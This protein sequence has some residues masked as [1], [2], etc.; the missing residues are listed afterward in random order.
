MENDRVLRVAGALTFLAAAQ[1]IILIT[2][3]EAFYPD[4]S[5]LNN[6]LSD[7]G[8]TCRDTCTIVYP[9]SVIFNSALIVSGLLSLTSAYLILRATGGKRFTFFLG[10]FGLGTLVAGVFPETVIGAHELGS[11]V[12]FVSGG[13]A[14]ILS[15]RHEKPPLSYISVML[16]AVV[17]AALIPLTFS[18]PF[19]RLNNDFGL[20]PGGMERMVVYPIMLW[21]LGLGGYLMSAGPA[22]SAR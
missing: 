17:L 2:I 11:F 14:S 1:W 18:G 5:I 7:F 8:A 13:V 6:F 20:G 19:I 3:A 12:A 16:G 10:L 15:Y 22:T 4:Y 21:E 9:S